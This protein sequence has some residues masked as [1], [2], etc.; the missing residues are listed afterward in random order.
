MTNT[1]K[2]YGA[3]LASLPARDR[4]QMI[5]GLAAAQR[6]QTEARTLTPATAADGDGRLR[7]G[8]VALP[9]TMQRLRAAAEAQ[10]HIAVELS[11]AAQRRPDDRLAR[12]R[13]VRAWK[14]CEQRWQ[15]LGKLE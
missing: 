15:A 5:R 1:G 8:P 14:H 6:K 3:L 10:Q 9:R 11:K 2:P 7:G 12:H 13:A 4:Q